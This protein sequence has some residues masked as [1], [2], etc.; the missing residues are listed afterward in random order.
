MK[1]F[2]FPLESLR[3]LRKQRERTAQQRYANALANC[4]K[5]ETQ[6]QTAVAAW[7]AGLAHLSAALSSGLSA[8]Q[9]ANLRN[10]CLVLEIRWREQQAALLEARRVAGLTFQEMAVA[11]RE[12]EGLDQFHNRARRTYELQFRRTEQKIF[13]EMATQS[14]GADRG[15]QLADRDNSH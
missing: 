15:W 9:F 3:V 6:L 14:A 7:E 8:G 11:T 5:A 12:R 10:G 4:R 1:P 13:D 2:R